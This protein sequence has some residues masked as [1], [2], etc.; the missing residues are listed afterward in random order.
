MYDKSGCLTAV[1]RLFQTRGPA[2]PKALSPTLVR[3]RLTRSVRV[4]AE[5]NFH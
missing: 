3:V 2:A 1:G 5:R 4:S